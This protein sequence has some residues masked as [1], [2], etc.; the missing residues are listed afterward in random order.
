M[1]NY[2]ILSLKT[3][4]FFSKIMMEHSPFIGGLSAPMKAALINTADGF[5]SDYKML[6]EMA[7]QKDCR[8]NIRLTKML[9]HKRG[10]K[11]GTM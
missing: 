5:A 1:N 6:L 3:H 2:A 7:Q 11:N 4:L 8:A 10:I 9:R